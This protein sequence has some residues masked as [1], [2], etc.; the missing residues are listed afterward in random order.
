LADEAAPDGHPLIAIDAVGAG[1]GEKVIIT[2]DGRLARE[3]LK[4][5]ATPV[6]WT[7]VGIAD[8]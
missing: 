1:V 5:E 4:V 2:S 6:R 3:I 7:A 8:A